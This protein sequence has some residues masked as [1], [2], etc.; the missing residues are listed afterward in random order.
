[1]GMKMRLR[2]ALEGL[3]LEVA[4]RDGS[5][6]IGEVAYCPADDFEGVVVVEASAEE[7]EAIADGGFRIA[8]LQ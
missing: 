8:W 7:L 1:M 4:V 5:I 6:W 2:S 3:E